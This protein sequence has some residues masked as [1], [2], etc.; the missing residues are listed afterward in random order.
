MNMTKIPEA[1]YLEK[2][3]TLYE[4]IRTR[5]LKPRYRSFMK[6][7]GSRNLSCW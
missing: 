2:L 3:G 7:I 1:I 6:S 5:G 4:K